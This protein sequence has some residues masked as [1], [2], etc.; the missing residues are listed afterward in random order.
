MARTFFNR[1]LSNILVKRFSIGF[2]IIV[3]VAIVF[4]LLRGPYLSNSIKRVIQPVL[5][6]AVGERIIID[7]AVINLFPLYLQTK[8][9]KV[10]DKEGNRLLWITKM[11]VYVDILGLF[12]HEMRIRRLTLTEP[13]LTIDKK[14]LEKIITLFK[15]GRKEDN[16]KKFNVNIKNVKITDGEFIITDEVKKAVASGNGLDVGLNIKKAINI[17]I[18]LKDGTLKLPHLKE[19]HA[20]VNANFNINNNRIRILG[21]ELHSSGSTLEA[22]GEMQLSPKG[23]AEHGTFS[24]KATIL[25]KTIA[26]IFGLKEKKDG[27]LSFSGS[28]E[29]IP[30]QRLKD[31]LQSRGFKLDLQTKG[32]FYLQTLMEL[33]KV[34]ENITGRLSVDGKMSGVYPHIIGNGVVKLENAELGTLHLDAVEGRVGYKNKK[35]SLINFVAH[36]FDGEFK[37][38]AFLTIPS[39]GYFVD[40]RAQNINS[41]RFFKF[42]NWE[43]P[44]PEG[45]INGPFTLEKRKGREIKLAAQIT[46]VNPSKGPRTLL[47]E[48]LNA[49]EA[50]L[51]MREGVLTLITSKFS[52]KS[53]E[54]LL[55]GDFDISQKR[56]DLNI[57]LESKDIMDLTSP[58]FKGLRAP[59][60]FKGKVEGSSQNPKITGN[61]RAGPGSIN[62]EPFTEITG[63]VTY[64][65]E[66]LTVGL[67]RVIH[68]K[69]DYEMSGSIAFRKSEGLFSFRDAYFKGNAIIKNSDVESLIAAVYKKLPITGV[70]NGT[71]SFE[72][73]IKDFKGDVNITLADGVVYNQPFDHSNIKAVLSPEG[74]DIL[75]AEAFRGETGIKGSGSLYFDKRFN[76][77]VSSTHINLSEIAVAEKYPVDAHLTLDMTGSGTFQNHS[78]DFSLQVMESSFR[79]F[80]AGKGDIQ[81]ELKNKKLSV[82]ADLFEGVATADAVIVFSDILSWDVTMRFVKGRYDF[83]LAGFLKDAPKDLSASLEGVVTLQGEKNKFSMNSQFSS[84]NFSLYGYNF[85]NRDDIV[86]EYE[87]DTF[88]IKSFSLSGR[89]ADITAAGSVKI[90]KEYNLAVNG[91]INLVPLQ[92]LTQTVESL[93]GMGGFAVK[94]KGPWQSP[95]L[96]GQINI[97]NAVLAL[98]GLPHKIGP[99]NGDIFLDKDRIIFDSLNTDFAG[100]RITLSGNG[101]MDGLSLKRLLIASEMKSIR[102]RP[103]HDLVIDFDGELFFETSPKRQSIIGDINIKK[104]T[105]KRRV[106]WKSWLINFKE[107]KK[108][109][110]KQP[111]FLE[112]TALNVH[113]TGQDEI[114]I[115]NNIAR[116]PVKIDLNVQ[117]TVDRFGLIG[118]AESKDGKIFFRNNEF[119]VIEG[120]VDFIEAN[121]VVPVFHVIAETFTN[122]YRIRLN[123]DGPVDGF[124]LS[125]FSDPPLSDTQ[126]F[127]LLTS[128]HISEEEKGFE[129]GIGA[130]EA[131]AFL[132]G[133]IQDVIE[134][135]FKYITGFDRLEVNPQTTST[136][137][138]SPRVTVGKKLLGEKLYV[139]YSTSMGTTELNI[140]KLQYDLN[141]N[142]SIVGLRD[143][144]GSVGA[145]VKYRFEFK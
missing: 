29:L 12:A 19:L 62:G 75:S 122:G 9:F 89:N 140:I 98:K 1:L 82:R 2:A 5:E 64:S 26:Q 22:R 8:G 120:S 49:I 13:D 31:G 93:K 81:G 138:V 52:T 91:K 39:G 125:L 63:D 130:G 50:N 68:G 56:L 66:L 96:E 80:P 73:H 103:A 21:A 119:D 115:D 112:N 34:K 116:T 55:D 118:R 111:S 51:D 135:R 17:V 35:F 99:L 88:T 44:F 85:T 43:P 4:F 7:K 3:L 139:T 117:G 113:V 37:G 18:S 59:L 128:G 141:K 24:G 70:V 79:D 45:R 69:L 104:A 100:G 65:P 102:L 41:R 109:P 136:G 32:S 94:V 58:Y 84:L 14:H 108:A 46:Y 72:G 27:A 132:T 92:A 60:T 121:R 38:D 101:Y 76:V 129:S 25:T 124:D 134:E 6:N 36:T 54:I 77:L 28:I 144:I 133:E 42:A 86:L 126:I 30:I 78:I 16:G 20:G 53:S 67:L 123:L 106:D 11:R 114:L 105:Y 107:K 10:F 110:L 23:I 90:G 131:T 83:L 33:F 142:F 97:R 74:I 143:E 61:M 15:E 47:T 137:A 87:K 48:R 71:L 95:E 40:A 145:D 127:A 57:D